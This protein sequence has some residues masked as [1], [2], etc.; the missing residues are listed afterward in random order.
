MCVIGQSIFFLIALKLERNVL[1]VIP[2]DLR[3]FHNSLGLPIV[4]ESFC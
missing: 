4:S 3:D 1:F 2:R